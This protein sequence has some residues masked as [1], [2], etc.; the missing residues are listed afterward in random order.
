MGLK[1]LNERFPGGLHKSSFRDTDYPDKQVYWYTFAGAQCP[2]CGHR[3]WCCVNITGTKVIC[4]RESKEGAPAVA[5][6]HLFELDGKS[7]IKF[8]PTQVEDDDTV[9]YTDTET[10]DILNRLVLLANP[11]TKNHR[12]ALKKRGLTDQEIDLHGSRGFGSYYETPSEAKAAGAK[13]FEQ[14]K[15]VA[16]QNDEKR[17]TVISRWAQVLSNVGLP[18]N[19]WE[20]VPGFYLETINQKADAHLQ[21]KETKQTFTLKAGQYEFP[22]FTGSV[23]G[24]L[25]PY[26]DTNNEVIG[27]QTRVDHVMVTAKDIQYTGLGTAQVFF[28]AGTKHYEVNIKDKANPYGKVVAQGDVKDESQVHLKLSDDLNQEITFTPHFG[29]KYFWASSAKKHHGAKG[30]TPIQ[31]AYQP[32]I[33]QLK[34]ND[35][36]LQSYRQRAHKTVWLT[37]GG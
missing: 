16:D 33:A 22:K 27:F 23:D 11:L 14:A 5:G 35:P 18:T 7:K 2:V 30:K 37:E 28:K 36:K 25:V 21:N 10:M 4:M 9:K 1:E 26:Y 34:P 19:A 32:A 6:G 8:D 20:G 13:A 24:M 17:A 29:G 15:I 31:V 12:E 3:D